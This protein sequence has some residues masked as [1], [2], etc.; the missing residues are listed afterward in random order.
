MLHM[1]PT[2]GWWVTAL[3]SYQSRLD[4]S[5]YLLR[6]YGPGL[7]VLT[8][9]FRNDQKFHVFPIDTPKG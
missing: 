4:A 7:D 2:T 8:A 1:R 6:Y 9:I 5:K 3:H